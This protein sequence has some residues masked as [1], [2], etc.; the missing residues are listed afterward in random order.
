MFAGKFRRYHGE[1][2]LK[3]LLDIKTNALNLRD[4]VWIGI[5]FLQSLRILGKV[6]PD[7]L[8]LKGGY[9][10]VPIG[11]AAAVKRRPFITHDS[12]ALPGLAN[13]LVSRWAKYHATGLPAEY[14]KYPSAS[15]KHV[16][17][18]VA[19]DY[20]PVTPAQAK[21]FKID[22]QISPS[23]KVL[24]VT[25]GSLGARAINLSLVKIASELLDRFYDLEI[26]HQ[27]GKG[28]T[29]VYGD[30]AHPR[31][32]VLEFMQPMHRYTGA[33]DVVITRAGANTLAELGVQGKATIVI[34]NPR[35]TGGHQLKNA[36]T[37]LNQEA[38]RVVD[39]AALTERPALL[40]EAV[41]DLLADSAGRQ[42]LGSK[43]Q[44]LTVPDAS[45]RLAL[46][47]LEAN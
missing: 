18:L 38:V 16:G 7:M 19:E 39:E 1:S 2:L 22:L 5:G 14:Y 34:P 9:V 23:S 44:A 45:H 40:V 15:V 8:L 36:Q 25:G 32:H 46:L 31:L 6:K 13:R 28:N 17:V 3:H 29:R 21:Q 37:L 43:L 24:L 12:D 47:L 41:E 4:A 30:F 11:L 27:V 10:G 35:L 42:R 20:Q 33:A 26:I